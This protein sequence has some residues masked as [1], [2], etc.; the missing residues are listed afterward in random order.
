MENILTG[1]VQVFQWQHILFIF[2]GVAIGLIVGALPGLSVT[3]GVALM[4]PFTFGMEASAGML[5][6]VSVYCAGIYGG[7]ITAILI[8]TPGT[9]A[10]AATTE[11]GFALAQQG[12]AGEALNL[13]MYA[14]VGGALISGFFLL[15]VAPQIAAFALNFGPPEYFTLAIFGLTIVA[16]VS[17]K[18]VA[19]GMVTAFLGVLVSTIG[20]DQVSGV[21]RFTFGQSFL[22]S[23]VN[24]VAAIIGLFAI[25][26]I[27]RQVEKRTKKISMDTEV[28]DQSFPLR[29]MKPYGKTILRSGLIGTIIGAIPGTGP[30]IAA[31]VSYNEAKRKS[32]NPDI[33]GKGSKDGVVAAEAANNGATGAT[34]IPTLTLGIPGDVV[35]AVLLSALIVQGL[36]P[37]PGLFNNHGDLVYTI[38]VGFIVITFVLFLQAKVAIRW[39]RGITLI[40][41]SILF[42]VVLGLCLAGA[43][44]IDNSMFS[45]W[46]A[47][48]FGV[49]GYLL[50]K[51]DYPVAPL[52][53]GMI[54][55]PIAEIA[56]HQSLTISGGNLSIFIMRPLALLFLVL[57]ILSIVVPFIRN[58]LQRRKR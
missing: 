36:N 23:G 24:Q 10:S 18:Y 30:G 7:S 16:G 17:G 6:L 9:V 56:F 57:T 40:P 43:Y 52:L 51:F 33:Y 38:M 45:V 42:P 32:K 41:S 25:A 20:I 34:L 48:I 14:S 46:M 35:T 37:G 28:A 49:V 21:P 50:T 31:F 53:I 15:L 26:E 22:F 3:I 55:G 58:W 11:D 29:K 8:K 27:L 4:L 19:K 1:L 44:A 47:L 5:L 12:K 54:L 39:F 13:S 2:L